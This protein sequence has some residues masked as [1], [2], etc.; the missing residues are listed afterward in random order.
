MCSAY[1]NKY[2][3]WIS[4]FIIRIGCYLKH[5]SSNTACYYCNFYLLLR[6]VSTVAA[7]RITITA[8]NGS[9]SDST[10]QLVQYYDIEVHTVVQE[11]VLLI[12]MQHSAN[13]MQFVEICRGQEHR[14]QNILQSPLGCDVSTG[15]HSYAGRSAEH[16]TQ[17][18]IVLRIRQNI[19]LD[20]SSGTV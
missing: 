20:I 17:A 11:T 7:V 5:N 9:S 1:S 16:H 3:C 13:I 10:I 14:F 6:Y 12:A 18:S 15:I 2:P 19:C 8:H 4:E